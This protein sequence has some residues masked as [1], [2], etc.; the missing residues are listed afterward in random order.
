[1]IEHPILAIDHGAARTGL[2]AT[3]LLGIAVH[4]AG[5]VQMADGRAIEEIGEVIRSR[6]I[7]TL[8][9]GLPLQLDGT[10]GAAAKK[11]RSFAE[12]LAAEHPG[13]PLH[14]CDER[15]TTVS[16]SEK[17]HASG[18]KAKKQK[19][20]IDQAAAMEILESFLMEQDLLD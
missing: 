17:L 8:V 13:L 11:I 7:R 1:M 10:E 4:P 2:A 9:I 18:K 20:I 5:T 12:Q 3:D 14:F 19:Q 16:A 6:Q 15:L